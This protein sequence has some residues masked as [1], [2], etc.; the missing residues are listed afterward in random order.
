MIKQME[1]SSKEQ[2]L[3]LQ[4]ITISV[5][6]KIKYETNKIAKILK[7]SALEEEALGSDGCSVPLN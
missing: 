3:K 1:D 2:E 5:E 6:Q 7:G 4:N